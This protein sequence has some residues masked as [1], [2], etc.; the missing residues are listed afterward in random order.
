[1]GR[2]ERRHIVERE[3]YYVIAGSLTCDQLMEVET[4]MRYF[5]GTF[6]LAIVTLFFLLTVWR[7]ATAPKEFAEQ[8]GLSLANAGGY[9]EVRSQYAGFFLAI[10]IFCGAALAGVVSRHAAFSVLAIVFGGLIGG[11]LVSL[12][13]NRGVGGYSSTILALYAIDASGFAL[14]IIAIFLEKKA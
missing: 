13:L 8:L 9:N 12:G 5:F 7:S 10:A 14:A 2:D 11:R 6:F 4:T 1:M 3:F